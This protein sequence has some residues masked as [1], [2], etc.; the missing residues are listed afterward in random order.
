MA[1]NALIELIMNNCKYDQLNW[2]ELL[3]KADTYQRLMEVA[4]EMTDFKHESSMEITDRTRSVVG[5]SLN[6]MYEQM[7]DDQR[8]LIFAE[9]IDKFIREKL[10][11]PSIE[12]HVRAV[13]AITTLLKNAPEL[14]SGQVGKEGVLQMMLTM[15]QSD[16]KVQQIVAAEALIAASAKKKDTTQIVNQGVDIL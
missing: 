4:S 13:V 5:V 7:W 8:R 3:L 2:A 10:L 12:S 16:D 15:A 9:E 1:R 11:D 6:V 14:G